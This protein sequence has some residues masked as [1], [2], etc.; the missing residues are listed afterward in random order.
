VYEFHHLLFSFEISTPNDTSQLIL[1]LQPCLERSSA[2]LNVATDCTV[3]ISA[4]NKTKFGEIRKRRVTEI[5]L[6]AAQKF[7]S[8][9]TG[10]SA[11]NVDHGV[12]VTKLHA[13]DSCKHP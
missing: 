5:H 8:E 10:L 4:G 9:V 7:L 12:F 11:R 13:I 1:I 3:S 2:H 6:I